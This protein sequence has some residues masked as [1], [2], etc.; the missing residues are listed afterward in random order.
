[1]QYEHDTHYLGSNRFHPALT[2]ASVFQSDRVRLGQR[3]ET[4]AG[5][6]T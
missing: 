4:I 2:V 5:Y 1:M 3:S 6:S